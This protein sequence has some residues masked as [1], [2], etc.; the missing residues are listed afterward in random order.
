MLIREVYYLVHILQDQLLETTADAE[1]A[2]A[3]AKDSL[4]CIKTMKECGPPV[5][6]RMIN[7]LKAASDTIPTSR[8]TR[9]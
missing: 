1:L 7:T 4:S 8:L 6:E 9:G 3:D 5:I 2:T